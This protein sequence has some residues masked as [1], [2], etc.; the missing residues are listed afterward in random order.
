MTNDTYKNYKILFSVIIILFWFS[1]Y[2][3]VPQLSNYA[4]ELGASYRLIGL[5]G[6]A[7]GFSQTILRIPLGILSDKLRNRK[8]FVLVG[9]IAAI[10]SSTMIY[11]FPNPYSLLIARFI[12]GIASA[13][14]VNFTVL[15]IS[16]YNSD[17]SNKAVGLVNAHSKMGQLLA[18]FLGGVI[19]TGF[20]IRS[21]FLV[22]LIVSSIGFIL[23]LTVKERTVEAKEGKS[24]GFRTIIK[25]RRIIHI[26]L[27][28]AVVQLIAYST[29]FAFTPI[30]A[31]SL[32]AR[33]FQLG[34]LTTLFNFPQVIFSI[35][36]GTLIVGKIGERNTLLIGF[37]LITG[38][39]FATPFVG[40]L[41]LLFGLQFLAGIGNAITFAMLMSMV[42]KDVEDDMM[43]TTMGFYQAVF[44]LGLTFGPI[45]LGLIAD[46]FSLTSG[47]LTIG[48]VGI[49]AIVS[50]LFVKE[51][52]YNN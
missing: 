47:Y 15:Y 1:L 36:A 29:T 38:V 5:I 24:K 40:S 39:C 12:A 10:T 33:D 8:K 45:I 6:S 48:A 19:A 27:L 3:Y 42:I 25:D 41:N 49:M 32:G 7:Y 35:L 20:G 51:R 44:G 46:R 22:S 18:M 43:T 31:S 17:E 34:L 28:A 11:L 2:I 23:C 30:I 4:K 37:G 26:S 50:I 14:W 16:Y 52:E 13:T 21:I 9:I